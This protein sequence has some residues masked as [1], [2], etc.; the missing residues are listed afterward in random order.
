MT[1]MKVYIEQL[2]FSPFLRSYNKESLVTAAVR[3]N[4]LEIA[5]YLLGFCYQAK[6]DLMYDSLVSQ[7]KAVDHLG[8]T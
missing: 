1:V 6:D 3:G 7:I 8:N 4:N 5:K 2:K